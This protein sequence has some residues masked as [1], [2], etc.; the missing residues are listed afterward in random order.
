MLRYFCARTAYSVAGYCCCIVLF[1]DS[2]ATFLFENNTRSWYHIPCLLLLFC[3]SKVSKD[4][5]FY[6]ENGLWE[7]PNSLLIIKEIYNAF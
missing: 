5:T 3:N 2:D 6:N 1:L 7:I 4:T